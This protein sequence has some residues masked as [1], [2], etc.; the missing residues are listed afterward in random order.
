MKLQFSCQ[1]EK[2][3]RMLNEKHIPWP[4]PRSHSKHITWPASHWDTEHPKFISTLPIFRAK[5]CRN[6][7]TMV[8]GALNC[9]DL[10][11]VSISQAEDGV[12]HYSIGG[13][14]INCVVWSSG[15]GMIWAISDMIN[16]F[17]SPC[18]HLLKEKHN[19]KSFLPNIEKKNFSVFLCC[20]P[21]SAPPPAA[22]LFLL[23]QREGRRGDFV[24][25]CV[26]VCVCVWGGC[27]IA[28]HCLVSF[29][30]AGCQLRSTD[31]Q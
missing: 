2:N 6:L 10:P 26:C 29:I 4:F 18:S 7:V 9:T 16:V 30:N 8:F 13:F 31:E 21:S 17:F 15:S 19:N 22:V 5:T 28:M 27:L 11:Y 25:V 20:F 23:R 12:E 24:C 1:G 14:N 3:S